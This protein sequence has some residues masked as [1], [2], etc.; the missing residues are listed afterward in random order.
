MQDFKSI[1]A[2]VKKQTV[3]YVLSTIAVITLSIVFYIKI[4]DEINFIAKEIG[5]ALAK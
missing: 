2:E 4:A 5:T 1:V 3:L